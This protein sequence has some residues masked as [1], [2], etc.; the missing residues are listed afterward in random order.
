LP[1][2]IYAMDKNHM[3]SLSNLQGW[4]EFRFNRNLLNSVDEFWNYYPYY[5][6]L[7]PEIDRNKSQIFR[8]FYLVQKDGVYAF[9]NKQEEVVFP[10][11]FIYDNTPQEIF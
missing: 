3:Y 4:S 5:I 9:G 10:S 1:W 2:G 11:R 6:I 7:S 8:N